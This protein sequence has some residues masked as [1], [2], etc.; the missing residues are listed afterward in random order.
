MIKKHYEFFSR[1]RYSLVI[2]FILLL[3]LNINIPGV[4][5]D[6]QSGGNHLLT[7]ITGGTTSR[8]GVLSLGIG[9]F[10][11]AGVIFSVF[12][13]TELTFITIM[14]E[15]QKGVVK[16]ALTLVIALF[17]ANARVGT[18][19]ENMTHDEPLTIFLMVLTLASGSMFLSWLAN[20]NL[21]N[22]LGGTTLLILPGM[23]L[24]F[25]GMFQGKAA[26][27]F[28]NPVHFALLILGTLVVVFVTVFLY[29]AEY[30]IRVQRIS[31]DAKFNNSY[32]PFRL[33]NAGSFPLMIAMTIFSIPQMFLSRWQ[34][35][36][37]FFDMKTLP[38]A[39]T[40]G[41]ILYAVSVLFSVVF[42]R[43][44]NI[45]K[46]LKESGDYVIN[47]APGDET[48][49]HIEKIITMLGIFGSLYLTSLV[50]VPLALGI[51]LDNTVLTAL[52]TYL[53]YVFT[54]VLIIDRLVEDGRFIYYKKSYDLFGK[55]VRV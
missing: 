9:A 48:H 1:A 37:R 26:H 41:F 46:G 30:R 10:M 32:L 18:L 7:A 51:I 43:P 27:F 23:L 35:F 17:Q 31:L 11:I 5:D 49:K 20:L 44:K 42:V 45:T 34:G 24:T 25:P 39:L 19:R 13:M 53:G 55:K 40:Y 8:P 33:L 52:S 6:A 16:N 36:E 14:T 3:G 2:L 38:G 21:D 29:E 50:V 47:V 4:A 22:G 12:E 54:M 15:K 28:A